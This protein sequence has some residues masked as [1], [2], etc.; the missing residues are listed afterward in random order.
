MRSSRRNRRRP[1]RRIDSVGRSSVTGGKRGV[2]A[3]AVGQPGIDHRRAFVDPPTDASRDPLDDSDQVIGIAKMN[4]GLFQ[5]SEPFD[6]DLIGAIHQ[7]V[8]HGRIGHQRRQRPDAE[9]LFQQIVGQPPPFSSLRGK[10]SIGGV[11]DKRFD[12]SGDHLL[13]GGQQVAPI[14]FVQQPLME[15]G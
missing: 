9:R 5:S 10:S 15:P 6:V 1:K 14:E 7:N 12:E 3:A 4:V 13:A 8:G 11:V 2:H